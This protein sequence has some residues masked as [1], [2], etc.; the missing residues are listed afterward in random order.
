MSAKSDRFI[1]PEITDSQVGLSCCWISS[2]CKSVCFCIRPEPADC[3]LKH[4]LS[5]KVV[6]GIQD[7]LPVPPYHLIILNCGS[8]ICTQWPIARGAVTLRHLKTMFVVPRNNCDLVT[9]CWHWGLSES[10]GQSD[11][12]TPVRLRAYT[13]E[14]Q[15]RLWLRHWDLFSADPKPSLEDVCRQGLCQ[16]ER[17]HYWWDDELRVSHSVTRHHTSVEMVS[18]RDT[19]MPEWLR[20]EQLKHLDNVKEGSDLIEW[21]HQEQLQQH[22][23]NVQE[24]S[25]LQPGRCEDRSPVHKENSDELSDNISSSSLTACALFNLSMSNEHWVL[26]SYLF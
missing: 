6:P 19:G 3:R 2:L 1:A 17:K 16:G 25:D 11:D 14:T 10:L 15:V 22:L 4:I 9:Q 8:E 21:L 23:D 26:R 7:T 20:Q 24:G 12:P 5:V 18:R 13:S